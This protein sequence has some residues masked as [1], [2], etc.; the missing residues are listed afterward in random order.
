MKTFLNFIPQYFH[1]LFS[2]GQ[3][4]PFGQQEEP[5]RLKDFAGERGAEAGI[6]RHPKEDAFKGVE[7]ETRASVGNDYGKPEL[8]DAMFDQQESRLRK[9][10]EELERKINAHQA[11][12]P[13]R[14]A[15]ADPSAAVP[16]NWWKAVGNVVVIF[17][18]IAVSLK[19]R[20]FEPGLF[21]YVMLALGA[22][23]ILINWTGWP[24]FARRLGYG[25]ACLRY[26]LAG[27]RLA[28]KA[29]RLGK[30]LSQLQQ[31]REAAN[32]RR[33]QVEA[34]IAQLLPVMRGEFDYHYS[35]GEKAA[36]LLA[37]KKQTKPPSQS[38]QQTFEHNGFSRPAAEE[39]KQSAPPQSTCSPDLEFSGR[40]PST[41]ISNGKEI[42]S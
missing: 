25:L 18:L 15:S 10:R 21:G 35:R 22:A 34:R 6:H 32:I 4:F 2:V 14:P 38:K 28:A 30:R 19:A 3:R 7:A 16:I 11:Q 40:P 26:G 20:G 1:R 12:K 36:Q 42:E 39:Q 27:Y 9:E 33:N 31:K 23:F 13:A 5:N 41:T 24:T 8:S 17:A 29:R 37:E